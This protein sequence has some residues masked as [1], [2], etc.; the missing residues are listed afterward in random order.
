MKTTEPAYGRLA[1]WRHPRRGLVPRVLE[2][3]ANSRLLSALLEPLPELEMVSDVTEVVYVNYL[4]PAER[5]AAL[6]EPGL[7]LQRLGKDGEWA[8]FTF[9][10][11][12]HGHFGF[13]F[14]GKWRRRLCP[15]PVQTNWRIHVRNPRTGHLGVQFLTNAVSNPL[16][17]LAARLFTEGM[18]MHLLQT[19]SIERTPEGITHVALNPGH[20]SAPDAEATLHAMPPPQLTGP[21]SECWATWPDFLAYCAPQDRAL[22]SQPWR[23]RISRQEIH[24]GLP[25]E[26]CEPVTGVVHSRA[27]RAITENSDPLCFRVAKVSFRFEREAHDSILGIDAEDF[28][29]GKPAGP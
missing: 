5:A 16:V 15:S 6:V 25:L 7:E 1:P 29:E 4:I 12:Q 27:A 28:L 11:F 13:R 14:L 9:L 2:L 22:S 21:W 3:L 26:E 17:A 19:A 10:T 23:R 8:L 20:G 24:L 18:P